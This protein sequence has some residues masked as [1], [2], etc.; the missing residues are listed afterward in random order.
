[1]EDALSA[2]KTK[3]TRPTAQQCREEVEQRR[4]NAH[5]VTVLSLLSLA[6]LP[7]VWV[8]TVSAVSSGRATVGCGSIRHANIL[9]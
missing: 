7:R 5:E 1:M 8:A 2:P 9:I 3:Y 6:P 4:K